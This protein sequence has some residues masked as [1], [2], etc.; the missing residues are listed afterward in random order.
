M[1]QT[2]LGVWTLSGEPWTAPTVQG[3]TEGHAGREGGL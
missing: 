2:P 3:E 1:P